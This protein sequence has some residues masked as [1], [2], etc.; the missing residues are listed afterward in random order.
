MELLP[1]VNRERK[2]NSVLSA[3]LER[4]NMAPPRLAEAVAA[5]RRKIRK[6]RLLLR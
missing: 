5:S 1:V 6:N 2:R 4:V 3:L